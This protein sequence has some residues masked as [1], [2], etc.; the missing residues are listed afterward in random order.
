MTN[1][2]SLASDWAATL[3]LVPVELFGASFRDN[4]PPG[5][6][7]A[8]L[9]GARASFLLSVNSPVESDCDVRSWAWSAHVQHHLT[10]DPAQKRLVYRRWDSS[11]AVRLRYP[12]RDAEMLKL[13]ASLERAP[14]TRHHDVVI[15]VMM[16]YRQLVQALGSPLTAILVLNGILAAAIAA[17]QQKID[18]NALL[19]LTTP[20]EVSRLLSPE[21]RT[22]SGLNSL[23]A[24]TSKA[25]L[26]TIVQN[27]LAGQRAVELDFNSHIFLRHAAS[28][29]YQEAHR[30]TQIADQLTF[31]GLSD[32][33]EGLLAGT[34]DTHFTPTG[35]ARFIVQ[36]AFAS[37]DLAQDRRTLRIL[38]PACGSGVFLQ[39]AVRE[40]VARKYSGHVELHGIDI[41]EAACSITRFVL[42]LAVADARANG[43]TLTLKITHSDALLVTWDEADV[44]LMNPPFQA[45]PDMTNARR[46]LVRKVLAEVS[47]ARPDLAMAF[48]W[49]AVK[50]LRPGGSLGTI[51][52]SPLLETSSGQAW[53]TAIAERCTLGAVGRL[54]SPSFFRGAR[55]EPSFII[56]KRNESETPSQV[57]PSVLFLVADSGHEDAAI[58]QA[59][60]LTTLGT[61]LSLA[62]PG[63]DVYRSRFTPPAENWMPR[64]RSLLALGE[65]VERRGHPSVSQLFDIRQGAL[66]GHNKAFV[67]ETDAFMSLPKAERSYFRP[68]ILNAS[69]FDGQLS[70]GW[71]VFYPYNYEGITLQTERELQKAVP[72]YFA[73]YL[74]PNRKELAS[75]WGITDLWWI[76]S[77][78]RH[79]QH[80]SLPKLVSTYF[81]DQGSFA[82]DP[83]GEF[84]VVQGYAW[85]WKGQELGDDFEEFHPGED[86]AAFVRGNLGLAYLALFNS[87][88]FSRMLELVSPRV[89]GGQFNLSRRFATRVPV[90]NLCDPQRS[91]TRVVSTLARLGRR[92]VAEG[93]S[94][95]VREVDEAASLAYGVPLKLFGDLS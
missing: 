39:E 43:L 77:R 26:G 65:E 10:V 90:P 50:A 12:A 62:E 95:C 15:H 54:A 9:D 64:P 71:H 47:G 44:I 24:R 75:R 93:L 66:T 73:Q 70:T 18:R 29:L 61:E 6:H 80:T 11:D 74:Q 91:S 45:L 92:I 33:P 36:Q 51:L 56:C 49:L 72:R 89:A 13:L 2:P 76:L 20:G 3:G 86:N 35:L 37:L 34:R 31:P 63:V 1:A 58:R 88:C 48:V 46:D 68:A 82:L 42:E 16:N 69:I 40:L 55:V 32:V 22:A 14:A 81:G 52:P 84:V 8:L 38:D 78:D 41:S 57:T 23:D 85:I 25:K 5:N 67:L 4:S 19:R 30:D 7:S 53:R 17:Q 59:R 28:H 60:V 83:K 94:T 21:W 79:W 27:L 87:R